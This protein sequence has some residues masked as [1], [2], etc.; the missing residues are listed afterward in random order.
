MGLDGKFGGVR[1][2]VEKPD[3]GLGEVV[4]IG[5]MGIMD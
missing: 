3:A 2:E 4:C 1:C 5:V